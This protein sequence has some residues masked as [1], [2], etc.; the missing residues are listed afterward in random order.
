[1]KRPCLT[2]LP[3]IL[4]ILLLAASAMAAES[5]GTGPSFRGPVGLQLYS[6]RAD[7]TRNVPAAL[8]QVKAMGFRDVELAGTYNLSPARFKE[9]LDQRGLRPISGHFPYDR[10]RDD[11]ANVVREAQALGLR[12][13]GCAWITHQAPFNEAQ[14]RATAAVFNKAGEALAKVGIKFFY[15]IHGFEFYPHGN[16]TLLDLLMA[17]T[18]PEWVCYQMDVLWAVFP[19]Q[20]PVRLLE[21][22]SGRW[23][24]MHLK[25]LKKGVATGSLAGK[26][27]VKHNVVLGTGQMDWPAI[28][29][30]ARRHGVKHY[31]I[32]DEAPN[33]AEQIP[34]SLRY[35]EQVRF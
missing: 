3:A 18:K 11:L 30:A 22:H 9:M 1:M 6:L 13:A 8:D 23:E 27:D 12:Y 34:Q 5:P 20:D 31:Y 14:C 25:D 16:G 4:G 19:G 29:A 26:T 28:L 35:L 15:H 7:F 33:A 21:K 10:I 32:E 2:L 24:L 17:E